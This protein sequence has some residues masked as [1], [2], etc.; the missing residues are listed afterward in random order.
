MNNDVMYTRKD[1][2][3]AACAAFR[4]NGEYIKNTFGS[5]KSKLPNGLIMKAIL[6]GDHSDILPEDYE[7]GNTILTYFSSLITLIFSGDARE[8]LTKAVE[9]AATEEFSSNSQLIMVVASLPYTYEK[10]KQ[11]EEKR[12]IIDSYIASS[13]PVPYAQTGVW[14]A[15]RG[16]V[17]D[18]IYKKRFGSNAVNVLIDNKHVVYFFDG[19][20]N[21]SVGEI[22]NFG[23]LVRNVNSH[24]VH[25][26]GVMQENK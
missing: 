18:S 11:R 4:I 6:S 5:A 20:S 19:H 1:V 16:K 15:T 25:L 9:A 22:Y 2:F 7:F 3:A 10:N 14:I 17:I 13:T 8:F 21:W 23:G 24:T 12:A 26:V